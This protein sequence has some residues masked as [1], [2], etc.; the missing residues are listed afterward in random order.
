MGDVVD[1]IDAGYLDL[2]I[3]RHLNRHHR[4]DGLHLE[5]PLGSANQFADDRTGVGRG[6]VID[7]NRLG[8]EPTVDPV[9]SD[10]Q[11]ITRSFLTE[12][13]ALIPGLCHR[14]V[15]HTFRI[16]TAFSHDAGSVVEDAQ[17]AHRLREEARVE[18][19]HRGVLRTTGVGVY[20]EPVGRLLGIERSTAE[21]RGEIA[22]VVPR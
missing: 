5:R 13:L 12:N 10:D 6:M 3:L 7:A 22:V 8:D 20:R 11:A 14:F 4:I 16:A 21:V 18:E 9:T 1:S 15:E 17:V 19:M 2:G